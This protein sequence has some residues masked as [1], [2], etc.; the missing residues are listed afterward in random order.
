MAE[1][2][3][4]ISKSFKAPTEAGVHHRLLCM[5]GKNKGVSYFL[6][7]KRLVMGRSDKTDI[8][9]LDSKSSREHA[10]LTM[11]GSDYV[12]TDLGSQNGIIVND[13]KVTQHKLIDGDTIIIG[14]TVFKYNLF[15]IKPQTTLVEVEDNEIDEFDEEE[16]E[17]VEH[18]KNNPKKKKQYLLIGL[19]LIIVFF[20]VDGDAEKKSSAPKRKVPEVNQNPSLT[21][22]I[23]KK[24]EIADKELKRKLEAVIHRGQRE[25]REGNYFRAIEQFNLALILA[26]NHGQASFYLNK[27]KQRLDEHIRMLSEKAK[28]EADSLKYES[29][30]IQY[31][32][33]M[34]ILQEYP[35]DER[36]KRAEEQKEV[37]LKNLGKDI[38]EH[39]CF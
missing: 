4:K 2:A 19:V 16:P 14:K 38:S 5:T 18:S 39:K 15:D 8:Q 3:V 27:T 22:L 26:P 1:A 21:E 29:A 32:A 36:Y 31:C 25:F 6:K 10:E 35:D 28:Q 17:E 12:V 30:L 23:A 9:I 13:L 33:I 24:E 11:V 37:M 20:L 34:S 7:N